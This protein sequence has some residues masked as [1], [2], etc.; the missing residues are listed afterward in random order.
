MWPAA[1]EETEFLYPANNNLRPGLKAE[2]T[3]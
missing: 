3:S 1:G 2:D